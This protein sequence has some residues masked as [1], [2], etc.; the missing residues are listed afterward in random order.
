MDAVPSTHA[1]ARPR[2]GVD[3]ASQPRITATVGR[4]RRGGDHQLAPLLAREGRFQPGLRDRVGAAHSAMPPIDL[5]REDSG[6]TEHL[7][8]GREPEHSH[9]PELG[10][11]DV[12]LR[13]PGGNQ[14]FETHHDSSL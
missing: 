12:A 13:A 7:T 1:K 2:S 6:F 4:A 3:S 9:H 10:L 11:I 14:H 5:T 8:R